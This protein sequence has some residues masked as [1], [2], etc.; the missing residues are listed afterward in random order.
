MASS[1]SPPV[2]SEEGTPGKTSPIRDKNFEVSARN[3]DIIERNREAVR[4]S[5]MNNSLQGELRTA[6][7]QVF[8]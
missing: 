1:S 8:I 4:G 2:M 3:G 5:Y 6:Q 7:R